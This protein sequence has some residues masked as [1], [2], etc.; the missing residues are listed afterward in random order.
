[1]KYILLFVPLL[2]MA[3]EDFRHRAIHWVWLLVLSGGIISYSHFKIGHFVANIV[4]VVLQLMVLTLYF[5]IKSKK[6][7]YLPAGHLGWGDI[8]FYVPLSL[9]F[10]T[11]NLIVFTVGSLLL[12]LLCFVA[13][14]LNHPVPTITVPLAGCMSLCLVA[15][16]AAGLALDFDFQNDSIIGWIRSSTSPQ[17]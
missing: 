11:E 13:Y 16:T 7:V 1:M 8:L 9:F 15:V 12:T 14:H 2:M 6:L 5:S 17:Q 3:I 10:S 4:L